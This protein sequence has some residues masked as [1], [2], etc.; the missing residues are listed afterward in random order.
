MSRV[1]RLSW[2][3]LFL[4]NV[5]FWQAGPALGAWMLLTPFYNRVLLASAL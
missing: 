5:L 3:A 1:E 4:R 2:T